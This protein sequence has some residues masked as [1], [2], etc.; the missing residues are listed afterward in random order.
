MT[1]IGPYEFGGPGRSSLCP[2][3]RAT[4]AFQHGIF[5]KRWLVF[6]F[7][8]KIRLDDYARQ[9][10]SS[11]PHAHARS[12]TRKIHPFLGEGGAGATE[13]PGMQHK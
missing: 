10:G 7:L 3:L 11:N 13:T 9:H 1:R 2:T 4:T 5:F 6:F 8:K 12:C